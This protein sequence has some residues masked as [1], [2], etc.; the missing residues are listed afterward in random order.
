MPGRRLQGPNST[1]CQT[2]CTYACKMVW[3][4]I[5]NLVRSC[6]TYAGVG[7]AMFLGEERGGRA[8]ISIALAGQ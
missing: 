2:A 6:Q 5:V 7:G 4:S 8:C 1:Y 3:R